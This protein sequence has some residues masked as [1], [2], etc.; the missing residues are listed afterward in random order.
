MHVYVIFF[1]QLEID[2]GVITLLILS[3][4]SILTNLSIWFD[5]FILRIVFA[6]TRTFLIARL[7]VFFHLNLK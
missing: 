4:H 7:I 1:K 3:C 2:F 6:A 5:F